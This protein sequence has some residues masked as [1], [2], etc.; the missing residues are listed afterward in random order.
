MVSRD[1][2]V[3]AIK[4]TKPGCIYPSER[5]NDHPTTT[6]FVAAI[7]AFMSIDRFNMPLNTWVDHFCLYCREPLSDKFVTEGRGATVTVLQ[8]YLHLSQKFVQ[9]PFVCI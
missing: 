5:P 9:P 6:A 1:L 8:V 2:P 7:T 3:L 4:T